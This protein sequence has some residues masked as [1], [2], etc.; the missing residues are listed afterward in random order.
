MISLDEG[1]TPLTKMK[2]WPG[3]AS[4]SV[5]NETAN[6]TLS[7]KDR[8]ACISISVAREFGLSSMA[9]V[10]TGNHGVA[11]AAYAAAGGLSCVVFCHQNTPALQMRLM[12]LY[13]ASVFRGGQREEMLRRLTARGG[14][15]PSFTSCPR[16]GSANPFAIE[17]FKTIA[18]EIFEQMGNTVPNRVFV[19]VG[20]GDGVYGVWKGFREL[21]QMGI[22]ARTPRM[23]VCQSAS[24]DPYVR[25][26][27]RG[28]THLEPLESATTVALSICEKIGGEQALRLIYES[29]GA[30]LSVADGEILQTARS[31]ALTGFALEP[32]SAAAIAC[33]RTM[34]AEGGEL[35][36]WVLVGTGSAV[37]W[38]QEPNGAM[39]TPEELPADFVD[40]EALLMN[41]DLMVRS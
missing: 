31:L 24:A 25:A 33:A 7:W 15:F 22:A 36:A 30:A 17:G 9:A 29:G 39:A 2:A 6:P 16:L 26:F 1:H 35:E 18:F 41:E 38:P 20:S 19:P 40:V 13:G 5:K 10:S 34:A 37:K 4:V 23:F 21:Q 3:C 28:A 32:A 14:W 12:N 8:G 11:T 27:R